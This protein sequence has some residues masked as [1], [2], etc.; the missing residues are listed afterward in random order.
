MDAERWQRISALYHEAL[1]R[2]GRS[3]RRFWR[4]AARRTSRCGG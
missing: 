4:T 2:E 3:A 1:T